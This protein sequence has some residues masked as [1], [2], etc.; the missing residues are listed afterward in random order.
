MVLT[1]ENIS[2]VNSLASSPIILENTSISRQHSELDKDLFLGSA[3]VGGRKG[4]QE[5]ESFFV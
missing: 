1:S 5:L 3:Q 2:W 4:L